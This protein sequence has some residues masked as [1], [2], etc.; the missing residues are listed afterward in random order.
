[1]NDNHPKTRMVIHARTRGKEELHELYEGEAKMSDQ[2]QV[3]YLKS[4]LGDEK[5]RVSVSCDLGEK[6]FGSGGGISVTVTLTC[7]Q[8]TTVVS[9]AI[10]LAQQLANNH[11][12]FYHQQMKQ[13]LLQA[14]ILKQ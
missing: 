5:A 12:W 11:A 3:D 7:D 2:Q 6:D 9:S 10:V 8:N 13:H 4:I 1:M 14:G